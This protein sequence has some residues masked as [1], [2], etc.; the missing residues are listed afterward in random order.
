MPTIYARRRRW[1]KDE[2]ARL[3]HWQWIDALNTFRWFGG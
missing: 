3:R 1:G 2:A